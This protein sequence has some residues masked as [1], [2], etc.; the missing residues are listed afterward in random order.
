M[1]G[2][3]PEDV[4]YTKTPIAELLVHKAWKARAAGCERVVQTLQTSEEPE[5]EVKQHLHLTKKLVTDSV[6]R[7]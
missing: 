4:D 1:E 5:E 3:A 2:E 6:A 7:R